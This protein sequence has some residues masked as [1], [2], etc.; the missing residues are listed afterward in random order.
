MRDHSNSRA[1]RTVTSA[2]VV[3]ALL[4]TGCGTDS[5]ARPAS[6]VTDDL[7]QESATQRYYTTCERGDN[8]DYEKEVWLTIDQAAEH[9]PGA[10][11]PAG[12]ERTP[13]YLDEDGD[14]RK[15]KVVPR[16]TKP[17]TT[18][19]RMVPSTDAK[20]KVPATGTNSGATSGGSTGTGSG[21]S[22]RPR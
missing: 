15:V 3:T 17:K 9:T 16:P 7:H 20:S 2:T 11:C 6:W 8:D 13:E 22:R 21:G 10:A 5:G 14:D 12:E 4:L 18:A 19:P 1:A